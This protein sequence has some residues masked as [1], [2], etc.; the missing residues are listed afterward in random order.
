MKK[1]RDKFT[2]SFVGIAIHQYNESDVMYCRNYAILDFGGA[3]TCR[4]NRNDVIDP[5]YGSN[6]EDISFDYEQELKKNSDS[7]CIGNRNT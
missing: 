5:F 1:L 2:D 6:D 7:W 3:P 4:I